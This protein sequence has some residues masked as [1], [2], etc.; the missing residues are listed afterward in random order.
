MAIDKIFGSNG[1]IDLPLDIYILVCPC[2]RWKR[3]HAE[4]I[5][6]GLAV[7]PFD[8]ILMYPGTKTLGIHSDSDMYT[9]LIVLEV[10]HGLGFYF[11]QSAIEKYLHDLTNG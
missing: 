3:R 6:F 8:V 7:I 2:Y 11:I 4:S 5:F 10:I 1:D 9:L